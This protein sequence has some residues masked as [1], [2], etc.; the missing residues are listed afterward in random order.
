LIVAGVPEHFNL[1][2]HLAIET[3]Q[4]TAAGINVQ[5]VDV[6]GGTGEMTNGLRE[7]EFDIAILLAEGC[8]TS[9]V[10]G[11]PSWIVKTYV[12]S[13]LIWGIH[14]AAGSEI[15]HVQQIKD[16]RYAISRI[17]SGSHLMSIVDA[18]ERG[19][20][21]KEMIFEPIGDLAGARKA[22]SAGDAD[23]FFWER[24]TSAPFVKSGEFRRV[25]ERHTLWPAFVVCASDRIL[26]ERPGDV[27]TVLEIVNRSCEALM[28]NEQACEI[29][30]KRY[31]LS[32]SDVEEWF[33][34]TRWSTDFECP[35]EA[36]EQIKS[37]LLNLGLITEAQAVSR[38]LWFD[39]NG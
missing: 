13:P 6:P 25:G 34:Q 7:H 4:F 9:L 12:E 27:K 10:Q 1:P 5:Y 28:A 16:Q 11:N 14:V 18:A 8:V 26:K 24:Y 32:L 33:A 35:S 37:C 17:G 20:P 21:T 38:K 3:G 23:T 36:I 31:H 2:W 30:S 29:I 19:W 22:L 39:V 15:E